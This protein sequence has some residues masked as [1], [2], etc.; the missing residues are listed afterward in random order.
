VY[1]ESDPVFARLRI[2][3]RDEDGKDVLLAPGQVGIGA[4]YVGSASAPFTLLDGAGEVLG[5]SHRAGIFL[6]DDGTGGAV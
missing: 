2:W 1:D 6:Q 3:T 5:C 4:I